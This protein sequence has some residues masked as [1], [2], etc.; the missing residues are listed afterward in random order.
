MRSPFA[1]EAS[2]TKPIAGARLW[3]PKG[4]ENLVVNTSSATPGRYY[5]DESCGQK[6]PLLKVP[7]EAGQQY[8]ICHGYHN[9]YMHGSR[10]SLVSSLS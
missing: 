4:P 1:S 7:T 2:K 5:T 8:I 3:G 10:A 6:A 9:A